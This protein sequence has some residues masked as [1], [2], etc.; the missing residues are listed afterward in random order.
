V[1]EGGRM[2]GGHVGFHSALRL[3]ACSA[4]RLAASLV[5]MA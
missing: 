3:K 2:R 5:C 4:A 1:W